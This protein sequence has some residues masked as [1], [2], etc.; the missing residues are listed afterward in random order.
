VE[1]DGASETDGI[2]DANGVGALDGDQV[3]NAEGCDTDGA[4][5][6]VGSIPVGGEVGTNDGICDAVGS[7]EGVREGRREGDGDGLFEG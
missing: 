3:G 4:G 6:A 7:M 2:E 5:D 1:R